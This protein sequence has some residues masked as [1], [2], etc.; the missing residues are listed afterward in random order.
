MSVKI[1]G[2]EDRVFTE[3]SNIG[4]VLFFD[5]DKPIRECADL[6]G[7]LAIDYNFYLIQ[8]SK[9]FHLINFELH[10][11]EEKKAWFN[12]CMALFDSDYIFQKTNTLRVIGD[13]LKF[14]GF[15]GWRYQKAYSS[16]HCK[17]YHQKIRSLKYT[18]KLKTWGQLNRYNKLVI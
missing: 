18:R 10:T 1:T 8:T 7:Y 4:W 17:I 5:V 11:L 16:F 13:D 6:L 15:Y 14:I 9:G 3:N 12:T 2:V